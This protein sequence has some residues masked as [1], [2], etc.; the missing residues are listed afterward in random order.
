MPGEGCCEGLVS[1][2]S[3][4][5]KRTLSSRKSKPRHPL[6]QE[7]LVEKGVGSRSGSILKQRSFGGEGKN[8]S[9]D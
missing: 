7:E 9:V 6:S 1:L 2:E 3:E 8:P 4:T 5:G